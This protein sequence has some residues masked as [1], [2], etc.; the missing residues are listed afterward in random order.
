M[1]VLTHWERDQHTFRGQRALVRLR[2]M[3]N[4]ELVAL[5]RSRRPDAEPD[6]SDPVAARAMEAV[7][8]VVGENGVG[9]RFITRHALTEVFVRGKITAVE[10][11]GLVGKQTEE[12]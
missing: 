3:T 6:L 10:F 9:K 12:G 5:A 7:L 11:A 1:P 4:E 2:S 8:R